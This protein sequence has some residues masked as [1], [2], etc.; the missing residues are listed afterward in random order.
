MKIDLHCHSKYS[1]DNYFEPEVLL[2][3]AVKNG[4]DGVCFTEHYSV[5]ASEPVERIRVPAGFVVFRG[6][7]ISTDRGHL[8]VYG[9]EDDSWN[10]WPHNN[11]LD[12]RRV[13]DRVH[14]IGAVCVAAHPFRDEESL[15]AD[16]ERLAD[17]DA[18]ETHNGGC[19][20]KENSRAERAAR[21]KGLPS[22]GGSDCHGRGQA[23]RAYTEFK[24][25]IDTLEK[26]V[27]QIKSGNC[28][29]VLRRRYHRG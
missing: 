11:F 16:V 14:A 5:E 24:N 23:G 15:G 10:V 27:S 13:I 25:S 17:L 1:H 3:E 12:C 20:E 21:L 28:R 6:V 4:L 2:E 8:L 22:I 26:L 19:L 7:E 29:G 18:L 9:L